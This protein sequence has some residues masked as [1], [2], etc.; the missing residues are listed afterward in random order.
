L[1]ISRGS[2][3]EAAAN[4]SAGSA[5]LAGPDS[6]QSWLRLAVSLLLST[7][8][9]IGLWSSVVVLPYIQ[10]EFGIDRAGASLPYTVTTIGFAV[11]GVLMGRIADRL[12][13]TFPLSSGAVCLG[14]G[15][16][17]S[18]L[19]KLLAVPCSAGGLHRI[20]GKFRDFRPSGC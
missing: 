18:S 10:A 3:A 20:A 12:G 17:L 15:F 5:S 14:L 2:K 4:M 7:I 6:R 9:G 1:P 16:A 11:G 19:G 13:I 8:G